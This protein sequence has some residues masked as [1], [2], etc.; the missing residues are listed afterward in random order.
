M[1]KLYDKETGR[2]LGT[3]SQ[4]DLDFLM[5]EFEEESSEDQDYYV[6]VDT[7]ELLA[8]AGADASLLE[9]LRTAL[10]GR[11]ACEVRWEAD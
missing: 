3:I 9:T 8:E 2:F 7:L 11:E 10:G 1:P 6:D 5:V 4:A